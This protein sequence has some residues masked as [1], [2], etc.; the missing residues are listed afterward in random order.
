[1][2]Q[3][4]RNTELEVR[5][6]VTG[7]TF[8]QRLDG[9]EGVSSVAVWGQILGT[10]NNHFR[11]LRLETCLVGLRRYDEAGLDGRSEEGGE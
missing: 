8:E 10:E 7:I 11:G 2:K 5:V 3:R 9:D 1:M 6:G 4:M